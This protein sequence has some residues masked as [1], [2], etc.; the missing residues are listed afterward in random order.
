MKV[1]YGYSL[2]HL[3]KSVKTIWDNLK[4]SRFLFYKI[5]I[6]LVYPSFSL[7]T[8]VVQLNIIHFINLIKKNS[9][10]P[11]IRPM[12]FPSYVL[13]NYMSES[14]E[15]LYQATCEPRFHIHRISNHLY[16]YLQWGIIIKQ[17]L[18]VNLVPFKRKKNTD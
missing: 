15:I 2:Q 9:F 10:R 13:T 1:V 18:K 12:T 17:K 14:A 8:L 16:Q 4:I 5:Y 11:F 6:D 3:N 7:V